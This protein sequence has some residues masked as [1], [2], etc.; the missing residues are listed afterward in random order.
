MNAVMKLCTPSK[1]YFFI[2][3]ILLFLS[4]VSDLKN[5]DKD[6]VCLGKLKCKNK[7]L[8]YFMNILFIV[9]WTWILNKL[10]SYGW[11]KLS[12]FLLIT[13]FV[14]LV[15]LFAMIS[16]MVVRM[17]KNMNNANASIGGGGGGGGMGM[18]QMQ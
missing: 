10:C 7:P 12:W 4:F 8:Y 9:F 6:K 17:A 3:I 16:Y 5:K 14:I 15:I 11:V 13:P 1:I 2:A 18:Q